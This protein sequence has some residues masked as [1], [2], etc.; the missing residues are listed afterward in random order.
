V[1]IR[2]IR[3]YRHATNLDLG[4]TKL[5]LLP[6]STVKIAVTTNNDS[7]NLISGVLLQ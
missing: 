7:A 2:E 1:L 6:A 5:K 4:D 3:G